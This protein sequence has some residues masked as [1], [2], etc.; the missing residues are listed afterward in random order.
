M[1]ARD[2]LVIGAWV[3]LHDGCEI[4]SDVGSRNDALLILSGPGQQSFELHCQAEPLRQLVAAASRALVE[5]DA[6]AVLKEGQ[7]AADAPPAAS[8]L[9]EARLATMI[10]PPDDP[11]HDERV[12]MAAIAGVNHQLGRYVLRFLDTDAGRTAAVRPADERILAHAV[13]AI[14]D[15]LYARAIRREQHDQPPAVICAAP[16]PTVADLRDV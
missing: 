1:T 11:D 4:V 3:S 16:D 6:I 7:P 8:Q 10:P 9:V 2:A 12:L 13:T 15:G 14:A 5:M